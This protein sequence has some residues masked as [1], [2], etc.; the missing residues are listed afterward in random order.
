MLSIL[1]VPLF[2]I[3]WAGPGAMILMNFMPVDFAKKL[4]VILIFTLVTMAFEYFPEHHDMSQ[5]LGK[6][7]EIHDAIQN[8]ISL[9]L[10]VWFSEGL[11]G[12]R[13]H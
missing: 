12:K 4:L 1:G 2:H 5:H 9:I 10:V 13:I 7:S 3:L 6:Y 8:M 11:F